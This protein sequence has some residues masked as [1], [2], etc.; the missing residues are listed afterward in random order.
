MDFFM[1]IDSSLRFLNN[2]D[3]WICNFEI[4]ILKPKLVVFYKLKSLH[5]NYGFLSQQFSVCG[6][7]IYCKTLNK[8]G[9]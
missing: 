3:E 4:Q 2:R 6:L 9:S 1:K 8:F 7:V 5:K